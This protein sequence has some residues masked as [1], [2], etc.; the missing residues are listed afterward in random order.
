M[1]PFDRTLDLLQRKVELEGRSH[2]EC[3]FLTNQ[4]IQVPSNCIPHSTEESLEI[5]Q[6][7]R[8]KDAVN[9]LRSEN[10]WT[11]AT[12]TEGDMLVQFVEEDTSINLTVT[13]PQAD[14]YKSLERSVVLAC[15]HLR[16]LCLM[17]ND[18]PGLI[19]VNI[20]YAFADYVDM[21]YVEENTIDMGD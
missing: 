4:S 8:L 20:G 18:N 21:I 6:L 17:T 3:V 13:L 19:T 12:L 15:K 2:A 5:D 11:S 1:N 9:C 7:N 10:M 14:V 16:D